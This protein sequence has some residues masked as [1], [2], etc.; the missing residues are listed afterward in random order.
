MLSTSGSDSSFEFQLTGLTSNPRYYFR[1][2]ARNSEGITEGAA[3]SFTTGAVPT[4]TIAISVTDSSPRFQKGSH[5]GHPEYWKTYTHQGH[6]Y[7]YTYTGDDSADCWA[8]FRPYLPQAGTYEVY[9][10]FYADPV[11]SR[12]VPYT[13]YY[14]G[15]SAT[16][17][18]D[19]YASNFF[20]WRE[21][22]L[23]SWYFDT[24]SSRRV[25]VTDATWDGYDGW[26]TL[27][28]DTIKF[29]QQ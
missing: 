14:S 16:V 23:G 4:A 11:N 2:W 17:Y 9:A 1:A 10:C 6:T 27:N 24:S 22:R 21:V 26:M 12:N 3:Q 28:V 5:S 13:V 25:V 15:G 18:V 8:E 29:V 19:E 20:T 7:I